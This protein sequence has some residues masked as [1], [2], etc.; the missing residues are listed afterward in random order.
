MSGRQR[1]RKA[2]GMLAQLHTDAGERTSVLWSGMVNGIV[3]SHMIPA[4]LRTI[5]YRA[6]G[7]DVSIRALVRPGVIFRD[8][9]VHI[10]AGTTVNYRCVFDNR[11]GVH[12]GNSV[13]IGVGVVFL[14]TDHFI[15]DQHR[16]A[17]LSKLKPIRI[18]D[19][20]FIGSG[21][22]ILPGVTIGRGAV[23]AAGA[24]VSRDCE[25]NS[26][27]A[28]VPARRVR[29]LPTSPADPTP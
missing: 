16:R 29:E 23:V 2:S 18:E 28:G 15:E 12:I 5:L 20:V 11:E 6:L 27:Y 26:L 3:A 22:T 10:G 21:A 7:L 14:N 9:R 13:G 19:G 4:R 24:L 25:A 1:F 17:G 8:R